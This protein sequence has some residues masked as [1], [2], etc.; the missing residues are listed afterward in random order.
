MQQIVFSKMYCDHCDGD[1][2]TS[3]EVEIRKG[4]WVCPK[5]EKTKEIETKPVEC[6]VC[7]G[8]WPDCFEGCKLFV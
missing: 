8:P 2:S 1:D 4:S 3:T 7:N 6:T 5:C